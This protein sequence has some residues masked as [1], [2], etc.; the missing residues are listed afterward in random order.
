LRSTFARTLDG[1]L[2]L[3]GR[4]IGRSR[5]VSRV[6]RSGQGAVIPSRIS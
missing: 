6:D 3:D 4:A 5:L 2:D 1:W